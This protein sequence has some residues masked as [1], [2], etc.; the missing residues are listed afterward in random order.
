[1][2]L[3]L[4][5]A[6]ASPARLIGRLVGISAMTV[7]LVSCELGD[8]GRDE[9]VSLP[10]DGTP[11]TGGSG[12]ARSTTGDYFVR[13]SDLAGTTVRLLRGANRW[14]VYGTTYGTPTAPQHDGSIY[15]LSASGGSLMEVR[16]SEYVDVRAVPAA[17]AQFL[18][19]T[20]DGRLHMLSAGYVD[21]LNYAYTFWSALPADAA[22]RNDGSGTMPMTQMWMT[23]TGRVFGWRRE[24]GFVLVNTETA[25]QSTVLA[26]GQPG[27]S[28]IEC[29]TTY[30]SAIPD[31][32]GHF[33]FASTVDG[34]GYQTEL[35]QIPDGSL[36]PRRVAGPRLPRLPQGDATGNYYRPGGAV[37]LY[38]DPGH[39]IWMSFRWGENNS[40]D[41]AY[42]YRTAGAGWDFIRGDLSRN[43][44]L[45]GDGMSPGIMG[46][47]L[48]GSLQ[49]WKFD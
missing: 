43:V 42:L 23:S 6:L 33:Y 44:V 1:M 49:V 34:N 21:G 29:P 16:G 19:K 31:R 30:V 18:A 22:W 35:W 10:L 5:P 11:G 17:G 48:L 28:A 36:T 3:P 14:E 13:V 2:A 4:S 27:A 41:T 8:A 40:N 12:A 26:C 39:R 45:F 25:T 46:I 9:L 32:R 38:A 47:T 7:V 20:E 24:I 37:S 15:L